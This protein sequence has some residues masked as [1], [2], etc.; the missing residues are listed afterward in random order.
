G[1]F[2]AFGVFVDFTSNFFI[3]G[4]LLTEIL[5]SKITNYVT[6]IAILL[7]SIGMIPY[8]RFIKSGIAIQQLSPFPQGMGAD[9]YSR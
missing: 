7:S 4:M 3:T 1:L 6:L 5:I 9:L 2:Y 8:Q